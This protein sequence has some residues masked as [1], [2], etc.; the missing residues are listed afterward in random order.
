MTLGA[1]RSS[2]IPSSVKERPSGY[3]QGEHIGQ[4]VDV[5][6]LLAAEDAAAAQAHGQ[7]R[8]GDDDPVN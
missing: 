8:V 2:S 3:G 7:G 6:E 5:L 4:L 1:A